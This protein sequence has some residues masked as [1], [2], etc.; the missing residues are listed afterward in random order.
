VLETVEGE[1]AEL[2]PD[3]A[4]RFHRQLPYLAGFGDPAALQLRLRA[5]T[6]AVLGCGG[7]GTWALGALAGAGVG[8]FVLVDDDVVE[9]SNLNRQVLYGAGDVGRAKVDRAAAWLR[10]FDPGVRVV[11]H[12]L[13]VAGPDD[14][15]SAIAGADV[16][17]QTADTPP[18]AL[19]RWVDSACRSL[20]IPYV[21]GG[22]LRMPRGIAAGAVPVLRRA[23]HPARRAAREVDDARPRLRD[24]RNA[25]RARGAAP[26]ARRD[27]R[28][29]GP[30]A[31]AGHAHAGDA[32][33]E[34]GAAPRLP[35]V[36]P[37]RR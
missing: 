1:P 27:R 22:V 18:Y 33:G 4:A 8:S 11:T 17:V 26:P 12:R 35:G 10:A 2:P 28:D 5:S 21:L 37:S 3:L 6:V 34:L 25:R 24:R 20:G 16:L 7:L 31:A 14:V 15:G 32:L 13:R 19:V 9:A 29:R 23:Q 30:R 36:P